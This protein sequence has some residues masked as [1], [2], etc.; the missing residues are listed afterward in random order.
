MKRKSFRRRKSSKKQQPSKKQQQNDQFF[1]C[2]VQRKCEKCE[3]EEKKNVQKK[4]DGQSNSSKSFFGHYMNTIHSKGSN[5]SKNNRTFFES[6]MHD[7]F[8]DVKLHNDKESA[9]AA[10]EIGAKAFTWKNHI[11]LNGAYYNEG[12]IEGKQLLAHE[13][14]HVQQQKNGAFTIQMMPEDENA[15]PANKEEESMESTG[16]EGVQQASNADAM[17]MEKEAEKEEEMVMTPES[18]PD[19][20]TFGKA[21][22]KTAYANSVNFEGRT[23]ATFNG[24]VGSTRNL[25]RTPSEDCANCAEGDCWH[26]TGQ[27]QI[28]YSVSTSV[29][30]PDVPEGLTECQHERVRNAIDNVLAPHEQD[31]VDAFNQYN[32]SVTLPID[33]TGCSAGIQ[34]YVQGLHEANAAS[35]QAAAQAASDAL[36]PF[37]VMVDMDCED[38]SS[39]A[40]PE[41]EE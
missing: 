39:S 30:L 6:R 28:N 24:G 18:L 29:T 11:V 33:Y 22:T 26:Y 21:F 40:P 34:D 10:K 12:T 19:F 3:D 2:Q 23:D 1:E 15:S 16:E 35:R 5:L 8:G 13:L 27:L 14:K 20:Q 36:D 25:R 37:H 9:N 17:A 32:G 41:T 38:E 7:N 31:H 4:S